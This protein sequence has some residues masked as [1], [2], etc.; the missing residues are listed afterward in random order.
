MV[1]YI[2]LIVISVI[3]Y[4]SKG[5]D[6]PLTP[7]ALGGYMLVLAVF[8]G[9][10]DMLGGYDRYIY[11]QLFDDLANDLHKS[12]SILSSGIFR[13]YG[14]ELGYITLN[15]IIALFTSN[16]YIFILI[17]TLIIYALVFYSM[18]KY[19]NRSP[20]VVMLFMGLW[21]FFTFT[22]LRQVMAASIAWCSIQYAINKKPFK[23]FSLTLL[24]FT[25]HNSAILFAI[26]YFIPIKKFSKQTIITWM[27]ICLAF[28]AIG[29]SSGFYDR[30]AEIVDAERIASIGNTQVTDLRLEYLLEAFVFLVLIL[31]RYDEINK[32]NKLQV[33]MCNMAFIFCAVLLIFSR[34]ENGGRLSWYFLIGILSVFSYFASRKKSKNSAYN[35]TLVSMCVVLFVR[36]VISWGVLL[37]PYKTFF[38]PGFRDGDFIHHIYEY[39]KKYDEDKFY[40]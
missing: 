14:K 23:F 35:L 6:K 9:I 26:V 12:G 1:L 11:C 32:K 29:I 17:F 10:A 36:I 3:L 33:M 28:G 19:T 40:K 2:L 7:K 20:M 5:A 8:V 27:V 37:S 15:A 30:Y 18:L 38:T 21:F 16:R 4:L 31:K 24:A 25:V 13:L 34:S 39:D 22:Y